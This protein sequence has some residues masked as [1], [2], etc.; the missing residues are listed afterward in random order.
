MTVISVSW[1]VMPNFTSVPEI[2][3]ILLSFRAVSPSFR[4]LSFGTARSDF[5]NMAVDDFWEVGASGA[6]YSRKLVRMS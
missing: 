3:E 2:A 5:E 6:C 1:F 4:G